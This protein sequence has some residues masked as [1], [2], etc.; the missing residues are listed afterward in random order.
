ML[1]KG[2]IR[3]PLMAWAP[4][5]IPFVGV[6]WVF[7]YQYTIY[8]ELN[9]YLGEEAMNPMMGAIVL[10]LVTCGLYSF[11]APIKLGKVVQQAQIKAGISDAQDQGIMFLL[12]SFLCSFSLYK[13]QEELNKVWE[14]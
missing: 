3:N 8:T 6:F 12:F 11:Y 13:I 5:F 9:A 1:M 4:L 2:E 10:P 14:R 7:Y